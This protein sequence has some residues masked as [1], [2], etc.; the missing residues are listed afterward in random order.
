QVSKLK[1]QAPT[2]PYVSNL[3]GTWIRAEE[4]TDPRYWAEHLRKTV[5]FGEGL[6]QLTKDARSILLE[7][8]PGQTLGSLARAQ[9]SEQVVLSTLRH[10]NEADSDAEYL[11]KRLGQIWLAGGKI[12]WNGFYADEQR[13]RLPLPTYPFER[14]RYWVD[15]PRT[16]TTN[17]AA[18]TTQATNGE[19]HVSSTSSPS[20]VDA[21]HVPA[22]SL[23]QSGAHR[24]MHQRPLMGTPYVAPRDET[25]QKIAR[26]WE[27]FLS[28]EEVGVNDNFFELGGHSL[29]ATQLIALL[30]DAF[31]LPLPLGAL[32]QSPTVSGLAQEITRLRHASADATAAAPTAF[33]ALPKIVSDPEHRY[34]PFP[35]TDIQQAY[36][37]G[38]SSSLEL[39]GVATHIYFEVEGTGVDLA[40]L[41]GAWRRVIARHDMLRA[42]VLPDGRQQVLESVPDY[43]IAV[44]DLRG[45]SEEEAAEELAALRERMSHQ[46]MPAD[47]WPL[48]ELHASRLTDER[49]R[50]HVSF[51]MLIGD[52]WSFQLLWRDLLAYY[53]DE[54]AQLPE[55]GVTFRDYVLTEAGLRQSALY[56][57]AREY[58]WRRLD[59]LPAAP[60]L[61]LA[62][63]PASLEQPRFV[64]RTGRL[65]AGRWEEL[66]RRARQAGL[67]PSGVLLAA[68][69]EVLARWSKRQH[70][71]IN[72]TLF[73]RL[74]LHE[75]IGEVVGDFTS[76]TLLEAD[77]RG[78]SSF[79]ERGRK[80]QEQLWE[81]IDRRY[82][83]GVAVM[84]ELGRRRG[85][86]QAVMPVIF[87]SIL[88][89]AQ[90]GA[91]NA[92]QA[93][94]DEAAPHGQSSAGTQG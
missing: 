41:E 8:G 3:T 88:N 22:D 43:E 27:T 12:D 35:L 4:A 48:F 46:V 73:N 24:P 68:Y 51:D 90:S 91:D 10:P 79:R 78:G 65:E 94:A 26:I 34:D 2:I 47:R 28:V 71:M 87:T 29:L 50:L 62:R 32:F 19:A 1:L 38:R 61:P 17:V 7:I 84:R 66:K 55:L 23:E 52:A 72:L 74:P 69:A 18:Q 42:V 56:E 54:E 67:T 13:R 11:L 82:V 25:E 33:D 5:R 75:G 59:E 6:L 64:R 57:Q 40:R 16:A 49:V 76:L 37:I 31:R 58:W 44:S 81:D 89:Q 86:A 93:A 9:T 21:P 20:N 85:A 63:N 77:Y 45:K 30:R 80:L 70:F 14:Q 53:L 36:W 39:G 60:E 92:T 15:P 83:S